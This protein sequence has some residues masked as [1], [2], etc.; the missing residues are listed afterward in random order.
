MGLNGHLR[1]EQREIQS[2]MS[3]SKEKF[4]QGVSCLCWAYNEEESIEIFLERITEL[5][6]SSISDYEIVLIDDGSTD[7]THELAQTYSQRNPRLKIFRNDRNRN[8]GYSLRRAVE[9]ATKEFLFWQTVDWSYDI[10]NLRDYLEHL[11]T[12]DI[13]LGV[14]REPV[15]VRGILAKPFGLLF[16]L[17]GA[18][19][20]TKRSDTV[21]KAFVSVFNYLLIRALFR[22]PLSDYQNVVFYPTRFAQA[23][24][25]E[26]TSAFINPEHLLKSYWSGKTIKEVPISFIPREKGKAKGTKLK[27]IWL[28]VRDI[29]RF[30][31]KRMILRR[32]GPYVH[33]GA[34]Y[35]R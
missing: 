17:F 9:C 18:K 23:L 4:D 8:V 10:G 16:R 30:W 19:H 2:A 24:K 22:V 27:A 15:R 11:K 26:S 33:R 5:L 25:V 7:R 35:R 6:E 34:V 21:S 20:L 3:F 12:Y 13:V 29:I 32:K 31:F 14:R 1:I 28:A